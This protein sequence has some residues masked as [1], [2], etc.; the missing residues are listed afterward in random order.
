[1][2]GMTQFAGGYGTV[3]HRVFVDGTLEASQIDTP[4]GVGNAIDV[5]L[6]KSDH[7]L[8][9][10]ST[11]DG[12]GFSLDQVMFGDPIV[13]LQ[14]VPEL[15]AIVLLAPVRSSAQVADIRAATS[16]PAKLRRRHSPW[17]QP[18]CVNALPADAHR[19]IWNYGRR[20]AA[21]TVDRRRRP[22][23][24]RLACSRGRGHRGG[25]A[26]ALPARWVGSLAKASNWSACAT[27]PSESLI[28][29]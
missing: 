12:D 23:A 3:D 19:G 9:L 1:M 17:K 11:D 8:T 14:P 27:V 2:A 13:T 24:R 4:G 10:V 16:G 6:T 18:C 26:D 25:S 15:F 22:E 21:R 7:F 20:T 29:F 5:S 28:R